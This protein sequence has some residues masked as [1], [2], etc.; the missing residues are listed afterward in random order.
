MRKKYGQRRI[1]S[2]F[3][4]VAMVLSM[5]SAA[6]MSVS[7][8]APEMSNIS[9]AGDTGY[10]VKNG[11]LF[12]YN[13]QTGKSTPVDSMTGLN[14]DYVLYDGMTLYTAGTNTGVTA[15]DTTDWTEKWQFDEQDTFFINDSIL[16]RSQTSPV[17]ARTMEKGK[18]PIRM[19]APGRVFR[20]CL[21]YTSPSPRD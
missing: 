1:L 19:I 13:V 11:S 21:L 10:Y 8:D 17:Q 3:L 6:L 16:L 12:S 18:L 20:S 7:A 5:F 14:A 2:F 15:Y 4:S 9:I